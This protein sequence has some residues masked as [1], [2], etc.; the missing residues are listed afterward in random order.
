MSLIT[1]ENAKPGSNDW[2][3]TRMRLDKSEGFRS[4]VIEGYCSRQSVK[5]RGVARHF[6]QHAAIGSLQD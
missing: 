1:E 5:G 2:Q 6:R 4:P 3:L